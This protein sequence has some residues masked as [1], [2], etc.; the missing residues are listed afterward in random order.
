M[1][2]RMAYDDILEEIQREADGL[3]EVGEKELGD[4]ELIELCISELLSPAAATPK[5]VSRLTEIL[6]Q[7]W[8]EKRGELWN[9]EKVF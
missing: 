1:N 5:I 8:S 2:T 4:R 3:S 7:K 6:L 9:E